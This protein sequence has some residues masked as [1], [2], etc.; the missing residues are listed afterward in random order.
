MA[1]LICAGKPV[2]VNYNA[3]FL[4]LTYGLQKRFME[5]RD[6]SMEE[7]AALCV[8]R[9]TGVS[10]LEA[11]LVAREALIAGRG[12]VKRA[13]RC[14]AVGEEELRRMEKTVT[15]AT[16]VEAALAARR[17]RRIRT[18]QDFRYFTQRFLSRCNG[19]AK[20]RLRAIRP[21]ECQRYIETAFDTPRQRYK[22]RLI[23]S[24]VFGTAVKRGWCS[25]NPVAKVEVPMVVEKPVPILSPSEIETLVSTAGAYRGGKCLAA[26]GMMLYAGIRPHEVARLTWEQVDLERGVIFILPQHSK[27]GGARCVTVHEPL[28]RLLEN[29]ADKTDKPICPPGWPRL[30]REMRQS[31]G[32][33]AS[34]PWVQDVL[35]HTFASYYLK[36]F[37]SYEELQCEIGHRDASLLRTRY[38][39]MRG[40]GDAVAFWSAGDTKILPDGSGRM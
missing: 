10:V 27:T 6:I 29:I 15:F 5:K 12:N 16:A 38:V 33:G 19:L 28:R 34:R 17:H 21:D 13:R 25:E 37:R 31:A 39:D 30:W 22:A 8:L 32:W 2:G 9:N 11:S 4:N 40:V 35:R 20:R 24:G 14:I 36:K 26:V 23:L 7:Q 1:A 18:C 3:I